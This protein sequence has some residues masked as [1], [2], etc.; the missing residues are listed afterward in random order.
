M[1]AHGSWIHLTK[2]RLMPQDEVSVVQLAILFLTPNGE[3]HLFS[4]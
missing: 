2:N 1:K 3:D 4:E